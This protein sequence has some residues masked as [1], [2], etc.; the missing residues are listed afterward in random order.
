MK[1][2]DIMLMYLVSGKTL[3]PINDKKIPLCS[4]W[5]NSNLNLNELLTFN[6][7]YGW[8][9][10]DEDLVI[11]IDV[12]NGSEGMGSWGKLKREFNIE[13]EPTVKTQSGGYHV[14]L[15]KPKDFKTRKNHEKYPGIDFLSKGSQCVIA[16]TSTSVGT[17]TL[18]TES[19][20]VKPKPAPNTLLSVL[21]Y[22]TNNEDVDIGAMLSIDVIN[23]LIAKIP[24]SGDNDLIY[25]DWFKVACAIHH[26]LPNAKG[27]AIFDQ[28]SRK[29]SKYEPRKTI[30]TWDSIS[31]RNDGI[32]TLSLYYVVNQ[33][34]ENRIPYA[35]LTE[36]KTEIIPQLKSAKLDEFDITKIANTIKERSKKLG[37]NLTLSAAR[38]MI[39]PDPDDISRPSWTNDLYWLTHSKEFIFLNNFKRYNYE[40][41]NVMFN[42]KLPKEAKSSGYVSASKF[43]SDHGFITEAHHCEYLP[44]NPSQIDEIDG[45]VI[46]NI[47]DYNSVPKVDKLSSDGFKDALHKLDI[48]MKMI[49]STDDRVNFFKNWIAHNV[50]Y[51]GR[52]MLFAPLIQGIQGIGKTYFSDL[53]K[54]LLGERNVGIVFP[55]QVVSTFNGWA[56][57]CCVNVVEE[58]K[59]SGQYRYLVAN[60]LKPLITNQR[61]QINDKG[62]AQYVVTNVTNY[63]CFTNDLNSIPM[64]KDDRRFWVVFCTL[65][66]LKQVED[67]TGHDPKV[68]FD[69]LYN[70]LR[71]YGKDFINYFR[72]YKIDPEF[73]R[74]KQ[75]PATNEKASMITMNEELIEGV[76][77]AKDFI[78]ENY[79]YY[80]EHFITRE[81][82]TAIERKLGK[83]L[84]NDSMSRIR[85]ALG[86]I[87]LGNSFKPYFKGQ[88]ITT[89]VKPGIDARVIIKEY[90]EKFKNLLIEEDFED[91]DE[92]EENAQ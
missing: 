65:Q 34:I 43:I 72:N 49:F 68:W 89:W 12:K 54:I 84:S 90:K 85:I 47:F 91:L 48:H 81:L 58:L 37:I 1:N 88:R 35:S 11:D 78:K 2:R 17:Y 20:L 14:Y 87:P 38:K 57:N 25:E 69:L 62:K 52:K 39:T 13:L 92:G 31:Q 9:L 75:A 59:I 8:L 70:D 77:E 30:A 5:Q 6:S 22:D 79:L 45:E 27:F 56:T 7:N 46:I 61:I 44:Y 67:Y 19:S 42:S 18:L 41:L 23:D 3:I 82:F 53:L 24:N 28:L 60:S 80:N 66:T 32:T 16:G 15:K 4:N 73:L 64:E 29:S 51:M 50:Q 83:N 55:N 33:I 26:S 21:S 71:E 74:I 63:I 36:L 40:S 76:T 10:S 86:Y